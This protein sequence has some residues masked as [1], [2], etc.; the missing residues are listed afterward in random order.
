M[1]TPSNTLFY[2]VHFCGPLICRRPLFIL[3]AAAPV[4]V[5]CGGKTALELQSCFVEL[6]SV[7]GCPVMIP[8]ITSSWQPWLAEWMGSPPPAST[9]WWVRFPPVHHFATLRNPTDT[10]LTFSAVDGKIGLAGLARLDALDGLLAAETGQ[11]Y[12]SATQ[13]DNGEG[14][15]CPGT[16]VVGMSIHL[17]P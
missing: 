11:L 14:T 6:T 7:P 5:Y 12:T 8:I 17:L 16:V 3:A 15:G 2:L 4:I 9:Q 13:P 1:L 10:A